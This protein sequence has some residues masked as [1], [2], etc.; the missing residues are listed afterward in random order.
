MDG[1]LFDDCRPEE[2]G[3]SRHDEVV[4]GWRMAAYI[5]I[6]CHFLGQAQSALVAW[7]KSGITLLKL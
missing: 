6:L 2:W 5:Y 3:L 1:F 4:S 7:P